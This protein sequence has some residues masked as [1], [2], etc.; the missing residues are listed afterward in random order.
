MNKIEKK[1]KVIV[2]ILSIISLLF[3]IY[4][5]FD[6]YK[7]GIFITSDT[8]F[9]MNRLYEIRHAFFNHQLPSW[10]SFNSFNSVGQ[11]ISGMYPDISLWPYVLITN[12]LS[13]GLQIIAIKFL[14][15]ITTCLITF[16]TLKNNRLSIQISL[17][18]ALVYSLSGYALNEFLFEFQPGT[19]IVF[20][21]SIPILLWIKQVFFTDKI[22]LKIIVQGSLLL[23]TVIFSHVLSVVIIALIYLL[24][25]GIYL[26]NYRFN[27]NTIINTASSVVLSALMS[28]PII[29]RIYIIGKSSITKPF[30]YG[31]VWAD[32]VNK[33][34]VN[35]NVNSRN[36]YSLITIII[37]AIVLIYARKTTKLNSGLLLQFCITVLC[38]NIIPWENVKNIPGLNLLQFTPWRFGPWLC[39]VPILLL[40]FAKL[41]TNKLKVLMVLLTL[42]MV[43]GYTNYKLFHYSDTKRYFVKDQHQMEYLKAVIV[44]DY[45]PLGTQPAGIKNDVSKDAV[46]MN[47]HP[48]IKMGNKSLSVARTSLPDGIN[49][50]LKKSSVVDSSVLLPVYGYKSLLN[51][52][53][54]KVDGKRISL[55]NVEIKH[56]HLNV[57][58]NNRDI[59]QIEV[60]Y[61]NPSWYR[62][63]V[64]I[65]L[66]VYGMLFA[67][68]LKFNGK[69]IRTG[70]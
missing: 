54:I 28:L 27:L 12:F 37:L 33:L 3:S 7:N 1:E 39:T 43:G 2:S 64:I 16:V 55:N 58:I 65:S 48:H 60:R 41:K 9:H 22:D 62:P 50:S 45:T 6:Q 67:W 53:S 66:V 44:R 19:S 32:D 5:A 29:V 18:G 57:K 35:L 36:G 20:A 31:A 59:K 11:A 70:E 47:N 25:W 42:C 51:N 26:F 52:Y 38:T 56:G 4:L 24:A 68:M 15:L 61:H 46:E 30:A 14:I 13:F 8:G 34:F 17:L 69:L 40:L 49:L 21:L 10:V 63:L 23:T